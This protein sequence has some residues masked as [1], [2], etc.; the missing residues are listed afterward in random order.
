MV[1]TNGG[2][3]DAEVKVM[4]GQFKALA[5]PVRLKIV[6]HLVEGECC[7]CD[8]VD[9]VGMEEGVLSQQPSCIDG[10]PFLSGEGE[11]LQMHDL[12]P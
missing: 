7:V 9:L 4:A 11:L 2:Y 6:L 8:L 1:A 5:H 3:S 10:V 12:R